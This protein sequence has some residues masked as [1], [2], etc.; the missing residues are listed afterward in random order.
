MFKYFYMTNC[1]PTF[2][3]INVNVA[4]SLFLSINQA[5]KT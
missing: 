4:K 1:K 3:F 2:V 5:N